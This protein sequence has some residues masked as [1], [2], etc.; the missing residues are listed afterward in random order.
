MKGKPNNKIGQIN[1]HPP[2]PS[3]LHLI[4]DTFIL[5]FEE[6]TLLPSNAPLQ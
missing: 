3:H 4:K 5:K 6:K 1:L 2:S